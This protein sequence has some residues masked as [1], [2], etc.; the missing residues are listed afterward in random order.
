MQQLGELWRSLDA[1]RRLIVAGATLATLL[2]VLAVAGLSRGPGQMALL[3]AGLDPRGAGEVITALEARGVA[4]EVRG[5][6]IRVPVAERDA[7]RMSLA[8]EGLPA[9]GGEGY[10]LLDSLSG[11]GTTAQMFDAAYWR[12]K[13][14]ELA[15]TIA[16][17]PQV[18][19]AR[20]HLAVPPAGG[21][22]EPAPP[23]ASVAVTVAGGTLSA[24]QA[25]AIRHLVASAVAGLAPEAVTVVDALRGTVI[26]GEDAVPGEADRAAQ[27][28]ASLLR[29]LEARVGP[30][31]AM[32]EVS[33]EAVT[34]REAIT[35]RRLDPAGRVAI[36]SETVETTGS[37]TDTRPGSVTVASNLPEG[38]AAGSGQSQSRES[39]TRE[40]TNFELS[41]TTREV[42]R[43]PGAIRRLGIAILVD[44]IEGAD[45]W[46]PRPEAELAD[47]RDLAASAA[48][49]DP[50]RGDTLTIRSMPFEPLA[51]AGTL[52]EPGPLAGVTLDAMALIQLA[53][54]AV[55]ALVLGLFVLR[56][57]LT[58]PPQPAALPAPGR[59][60]GTAV[61][62]LTGEID[63]G[64]Y[65]AGMPLVAGGL[66]ALGSFVMPAEDGPEDPVARLRR[67]IAER[68]A[69]SAD[70]LRGWME[71]DAR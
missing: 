2:A 22:R 11:F 8:G 60:D 53:V 69:E 50:G 31:R 64:D 28:R 63:E 12:A 43:V 18:R 44:G 19:A 61:P 49:I 33:V 1:R 67:L 32:V 48:G 41:E 6:A 54:L 20:V 21:F 52:G 14:G 7:L 23:S 58:R 26:G 59:D 17:G 65:P 37:A 13:E 24:G 30:G 47:L 62:V 15:R 35:E 16:A 68:R 27:L 46:Q 9:T 3:Y 10:E 70:I 51:E 66:P 25:K 36:A 5:D 56:P 42:L 57:I 4:Y 38:D 45:G 34:E 29:L 40:R 71:E 39:T 55:T